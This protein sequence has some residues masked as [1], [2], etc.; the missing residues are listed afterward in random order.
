[1]AILSYKNKASR[2]VA[3]QVNSKEARRLLPVQLRR[4]T[5]LKLSIL[6]TAE[7]LD[8]IGSVPGLGLEKLKRDRAGQ[9]SIRI[10]DQY[11]ICFIWNGS[12]AEMVEIVDYH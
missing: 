4:G 8:Q 10:N 6:D 11:R 2:D 1:M 9:H 12:D 5:R 7:A 3:E